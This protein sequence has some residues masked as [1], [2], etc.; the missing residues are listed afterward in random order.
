MATITRRNR[1]SGA[2]GSLALPVLNRTRANLK[3]RHPDV[4]SRLKAEQDAWNATMLPFTSGND[5]DS[6]SGEDLADHRGAP[7]T[8]Y[9]PDGLVRGWRARRE[10]RR[11]AASRMVVLGRWAGGACLLSCRGHP[12]RHSRRPRL[13]PTASA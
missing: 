9:G 4:F 1:L 12:H 5:S 8:I 10:A 11:G 2:G 13:R 3:D 7:G 6:L